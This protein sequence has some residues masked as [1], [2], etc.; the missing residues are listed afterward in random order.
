LILQD[1]RYVLTFLKECSIAG[2]ARVVTAT[3]RTII[4]SGGTLAVEAIIWS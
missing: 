2:R 1:F 4:F 3:I